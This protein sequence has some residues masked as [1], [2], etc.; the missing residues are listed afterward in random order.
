[1]YYLERDIARVQLRNAHSA[2]ADVGIY[3]VI[4]DHICLQHGMELSKI[5]IQSPRN[6]KPY[7]GFS[8][9]H[10]RFLS[11]DI[12]MIAKKSHRDDWAI[13]HLFLK[14]TFSL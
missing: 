4:L 14:A 13:T 2:I 5:C 10:R 6:L 1:M 7:E 11:T 8:D 3:S 12:P 9:I